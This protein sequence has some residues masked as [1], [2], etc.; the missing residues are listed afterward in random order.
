MTDI[1]FVILIGAVGRMRLWGY[2]PF[3]FG[4]NRR[5]DLWGI[6]SWGPGVGTWPAQYT[7]NKPNETKCD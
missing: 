5:L 1:N 6:G 4:L 3:V 2:S 7:L